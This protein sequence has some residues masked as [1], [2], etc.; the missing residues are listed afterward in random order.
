MNT[1]DSKGNHPQNYD[2]LLVEIA[3]YVH[4]VP[5]TSDLAYQ[6]A[7]WS[8][9][10]SL[11]CL[12]LALSSSKCQALLGATIPGTMVPLG[13]RVP[14]TSYI[15]DPIKAAFDIGSCIR[16]LDYNDTWLAAEWAH[17][18]DNLGGILATADFL[19]RQLDSARKTKQDTGLIHSIQNNIKKI[20]MFDL[21]TMMIKAYEIQGILALNHSF[22]RLGLDHVILVKV[23]TTAVVSKLL[24]LS[25]T[26]TMDALSNAWIDN[27]SLR[28]YRHAP[29]T[30]SR[31]SWAAGD[32]TSRGVALAW[33]TMRGEQG[34]P[35]A[36][37][38]KKWGFQEVLFKGQA[39]TLAR[40]LQSYVME[41]ILYKVAFPAEFHA[42]TAVEA[43]LQLYPL[44]KDRWDDIERV[45]LTTQE[46]AIRIIHKEG[47]L[48]N[49]AD[50]DHCL[51]YMVA[52]GLLYGEIMPEHYSDETAENP[53]LDR[54]RQKMHVK[55]DKA[56]SQ[57]YYD[58]EKRSI[59]NAIQIFFK[60]GSHTE[61]LRID[62]PLGHKRRRN[63]ALKL[64]KDKFHL[65]V[66]TRYTG[67]Q[68]DRI[69]VFWDKPE[70]WSNMTVSEFMEVWKI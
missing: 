37:S 24:G 19:S 11:G 47:P 14:G 30:G 42:Q 38:A 13:A 52:V 39:L 17:P 50:R 34:Y 41:N 1:K 48:T 9:L 63:E 69:E 18:S 32:A 8:L 3:D 10:D 12:L 58:P 65:A 67:L 7:H 31:K 62:Y 23:A 21:L 36:L 35:S 44:V 51:Q 15:L 56:F 64:L 45:E 53:K 49:Y 4:D 43:A 60:D 68:A 40:P 5:I 28:T 26:Q 66:R 16:W 59:A 55:E 2:Q 29:N 57:D 54:L 20:T 61:L 46:P 25:K 33:M 22:N 6:T 70:D 27:S